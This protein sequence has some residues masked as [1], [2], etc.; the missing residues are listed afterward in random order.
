[1]ARASKE[2]SITRHC[3]SIPGAQISAAFCS[4]SSHPVTSH[5][6]KLLLRKAN[7]MKSIQGGEM[8]KPWKQFAFI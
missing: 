5:A 3:T 2:G 1:M 4:W 8:N 6:V 7:A